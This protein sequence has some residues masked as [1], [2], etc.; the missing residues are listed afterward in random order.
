[1]AAAQARADAMIAKAEADGRAAQLEAAQFMAGQANASVGSPGARP[2]VA[3]IDPSQPLPPVRDLFKQAFEGF[4]DSVGETF[5]DRRGI[6]DPGPGAD[7]NRPPPELEDE[8]SATASRPRSG[9]RA[10][11]ARAPYRA[12]APPAIE[13][14]RFGVTGGTQLEEVVTRLK[15]TGLSAAP[16]RVFGVYRVPDRFDQNKNSENRAYVEWEIAHAPGALAARDR[17]R[18]P[19]G[20]RAR[21]PLGRAQPRRARRARRGRRRDV[22]RARRPAAGGLPRAHAAA[23]HP[24]QRRRVRQ[25]LVRARRRRAR[26]EPPVGGGDARAGGDAGR[27]AARAGRAAR[28]A[29]PRRDPRLGGGRRVGRARPQGPAALPVAAAPPPEQ[30]AGADDRLPRGRRRPPRGRATACRSRAPTRRAGS[31]TCR[32]RARARTSAPR[33]S[34]AAPTAP[35][36]GACRR[37]STSS[38]PTATGRSTRT[39]VRAG[40]PTRRRCCGR[41]STTAATCGRRSNRVPP[42][43]VVPL[44]GLR[45]V[46][47]ARSRPRVPAGVQPQREAE[48]RA[49]LR[50]GRRL[51][52]RHAHDLRQAE[53]VAGRVAEATRRCRTGAPR[54]CRRTRRRGP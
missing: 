12:A 48:P 26:A 18:A 11:Q 52:R 54:A 35:S 20:V 46:Q 16:E 36:A 4:R 15:A 28:P 17:R 42:A 34:C 30:L 41:G 3:P 50:E 19:D 37:P 39:D 49:V 33:R 22:L 9:R 23:P 13:F 6:I 2:P 7:L 14:T 32:W 29:L 47:P 31:P 44:R 45:H 25:E 51:D 21:G 1:M 38:S 53:V 27:G 8:R 5:D 40:A 43:A 10:T 24:R